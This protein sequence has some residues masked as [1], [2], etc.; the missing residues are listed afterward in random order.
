M[1]SHVDSPSQP[2]S[3]QGS[4]KKLGSEKNQHERR[5]KVQ[6]LMD[7]E[8]RM[9]SRTT[10]VFVKYYFMRCMRFMQS[11][12]RSSRFLRGEPEVFMG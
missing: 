3:G 1:H 4:P 11:F 2:D 8:L 5:L 12:P 7:I 6:L 9:V 10:H